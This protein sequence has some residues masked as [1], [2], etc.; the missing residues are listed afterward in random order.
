MTCGYPALFLFCGAPTS[1]IIASPDMKS[2]IRIS[3]A[4]PVECQTEAQM[5][6][7]IR[8]IVADHARLSVEFERVEH[9]T[10][11]YRAGMTSFSSVALMIALE[12]EFD[13]EFPD[14]MLS[15]NVFESIDSIADAIE[16]LQQVQ[17]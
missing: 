4:L 16:R 11:L 14:G 15:R 6:D 3:S 9:S 17:S 8:K 10:N 13:L 5:K 12:N 7:K 2:A 1:P